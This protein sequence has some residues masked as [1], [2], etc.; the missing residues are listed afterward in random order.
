MKETSDVVSKTGFLRLS[1]FRKALRAFCIQIFFK[2]A[3][4][5]HQQES[6]FVSQEQSKHNPRITG[7]YQND[8]Q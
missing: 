1:H 3:V 8:Q 5:I 7:K 6:V 2:V 4:F